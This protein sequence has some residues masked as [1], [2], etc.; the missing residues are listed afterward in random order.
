MPGTPLVVVVGVTEV[1]V[2]EVALA[3]G[4]FLDSILELALVGNTVELALVDGVTMDGSEVV[5]SGL[6]DRVRVCAEVG[7]KEK[8]GNVVGVELLWPKPLLPP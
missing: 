3:C 6:L 7:A 4:G 1:G 5:R 2:T 8:F